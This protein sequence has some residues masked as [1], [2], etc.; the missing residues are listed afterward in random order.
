MYH[1][2]FGD[3]ALK[4]VCMNRGNSQIGEPRDIALGV[5]DVADPKIHAHPTSVNR[6]KFGTSASNVTQRNP[7][8]WK[9]AETASSWGESVVDP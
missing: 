9:S 6:V 1:A 3:S 4:C 2:E 7:K 5:A 8:N